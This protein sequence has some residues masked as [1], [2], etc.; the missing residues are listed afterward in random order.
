[1]RTSVG[2]SSPYYL[3][4]HDQGCFETMCIVK[5]QPKKLFGS[6]NQ[7]SSQAT[8]EHRLDVLSTH[9]MAL[10]EELF[11]SHRL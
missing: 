10:T 4:L 3:Y 5:T 6:E 8:G 1:M 11:Q 9:A 7:R 2:K